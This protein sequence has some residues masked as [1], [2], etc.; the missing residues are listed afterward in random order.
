MKIVKAFALLILLLLAGCASLGS[1]T[2][3]GD[4][5]Q[6]QEATV[7]WLRMTGKGFV[8][9]D[10]TCNVQLADSEQGLAGFLSQMEACRKG[11]VRA[12][13]T[14]QMKKVE[15]K[16]L[17]LF[18][19]K[20]AAE[21]ESR[22]VDHIGMRAYKALSRRMIPTVCVEGY[23]CKGVVGFQFDGS[24][25]CGIVIAQHYISRAGHE[26]KHCYDGE[27][28][29]ASMRWKE[30]GSAFVPEPAPVATKPAN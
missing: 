23:T 12:T 24:G 5:Q 21:A 15:A 25:Y 14:E 3:Q 8:D 10:G 13:A 22:W 11:I 2:W 16:K 28:H 1:T 29:Y 6:Y 19:V 9:Q 4:P 17:R 7:R 26:M 30:S 18:V 27:Y 20:T